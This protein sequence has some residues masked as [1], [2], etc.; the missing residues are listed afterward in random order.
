MYIRI[1]RNACSAGVSS[2][3]IVVMATWSQLT[4][5][6]EIENKNIQARRL[7]HSLTKR[8]ALSTIYLVPGKV[9]GMGI[10]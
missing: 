1:L 9:S 5:A 10:I 8:T 2:L 4:G 6:I 7:H 3:D